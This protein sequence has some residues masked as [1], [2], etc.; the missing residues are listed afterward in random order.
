MNIEIRE[1]DIDHA[2]ELS[3]LAAKIYKQYFLYLWND[4]GE[5]Y[6]NRTY[7]VNII[8]DELA[9]SNNLHF[10][11]CKNEQPAGYIKIRKNATLEGHE[12]N[13]CLEVERIYILQ[14]AAGS[15]LGKQLMQVAFDFARSLKKDIVFLK[16]MDSSI[17]SIAFYKKLGF[18]ICGKLT[19]PFDQMKEEYRGMCILKKEM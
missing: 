3:A 1:I 8:T 13:H 11:A 10:I 6:I 7:H 4:E 16:S 9:D 2:G 18:E 14:E 15:G 19:L 12:N 17:N 5:W